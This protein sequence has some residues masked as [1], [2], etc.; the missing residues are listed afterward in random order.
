M[1]SA[2]WLAPQ[3]SLGVCTALGLLTLLSLP[4]R[5][6]G[7][8][9]AAR[10]HETVLPNGLKILVLEDHKAPVA[11]FQVWYRVGSRNEALGRTGLAHI[12]EHMMFKG[13]ER[14]APEAYTRIIQVNGGQTN[15]FTTQDYTMY[16]ASI[17]S[18]RLNVVMDL[19]ADRMTNV[20]LDAEHFHPERDVVI[21]ERRLRVDN[22][23]VAALFEELHAIAYVAHPYEWPTIGWM[24]DIRQV[25]VDDL[26]E[27]YRAHYIPNNA[28]LVVVGDVDPAR[29]VASAREAFAQTAAG[30]PPGL[31]RSIEPVQ[32]GERRVELHREAELPFVAL[33]FHVPNF[34]SVD[35]PPLE[36]LETLLGGGES[37]RLHRELSY[38]RR[39][40]H[41]IGA[42]YDTLSM[43]PGL[44][45]VFGQPLPGKSVAELEKGLRREI[46][47]L[48]AAPPSADEL[49]RVKKSI[50]ARYV[51]GQDSLF[52]QGLWLG[53]YELLGD[54]RG[55]DNYLPAIRAVTA[56]DVQRVATTYFD[57]TKQTVATLMPTV[58]A[59]PPGEPRP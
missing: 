21:E 56:A 2:G 41:E 8:G 15:A 22:N 20:V 30:T 25:T 19:E 52:T 31:V 3:S 1:K 58:K 18:D 28:F 33:A 44:F 4:L 38:R 26:K 36:V 47:A 34:T 59:A 53:Q 55:I 17:A 27:Y 14:V 37:S 49:A 43:D 39:L 13:T 29:F 46:D 35:G 7:E 48:R 16:F 10:V 23:P 12:L 50:E 11:T 24:D 9:Y 6:H 45:I 54:W 40:A 32:R 51:F 42:E 57:P 5:A